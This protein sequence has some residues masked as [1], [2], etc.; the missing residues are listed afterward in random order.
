[1]DRTIVVGDV[2]G[3][4]FEL[5]ALLDEIGLRPAD[6]LIFV[7]DLITKGPANREVLDFIRLRRNSESVLGN[8]EWLLLRSYYAGNVNLGPAHLQVIAEM[9][10]GLSSYM[11]WISRFPG[12]IDLED[13]LIVHAGIRPGVPLGRQAME[14][15]TQLRALDGGRDGTPWFDKYHG[16][17]TV[18]FGH[19]VFDAPMLKENAMGIDT[20]CVYGRS[21]T[22]VVLPD[23]R[24]V[25]IP[26]LKAYAS[27]E[28]N[29][30]GR[31]HENVR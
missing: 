1:M 13:F 23:R 12:Y 2:H 22:A 29:D 7:G 28:E 20:G 11:E 4:Y 5:R 15:L 30:R 9:G 19:R 16:A 25:G 31:E 14:D 18:I 8:N 21:L 24:L 6:R 27:K 3:C 17:K 10:G 26:A